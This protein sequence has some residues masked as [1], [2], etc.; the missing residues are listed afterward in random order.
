M[1]SL[2]TI[3]RA[4]ALTSLA[5]AG[6]PFALSSALELESEWGRRAAV[7]VSC[8]FSWNISIRDLS[9]SP[10]CPWSGFSVF[11]KP[12]QHQLRPISSSQTF[13]DSRERADLWSR[14]HPG[15]PRLP[16]LSWKWVVPMQSFP[17]S[18]SPASHPRVG[19]PGSFPPAATLSEIS[20]PR[21]DSCLKRQ[22]SFRVHS[23]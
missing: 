9:K 18:L 11:I 20:A 13:H 22:F 19:L 3:S 21:T 5:L 7:S 12:R 16:H 2:L 6:S 4:L 17:L 1:V 10:Y 8:E 14:I 15:T 23:V